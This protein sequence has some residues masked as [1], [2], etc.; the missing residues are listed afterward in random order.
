MNLNE[1][2]RWILNT[3]EEDS[4]WVALDGQVQDNV[5]ALPD[6]SKFKDQNPESQVS[7][8][9]VSKS[10]DENAE[11]IIFEKAV[12]ASKVKVAAKGGG[13]NRGRFNVKAAERSGVKSKAPS[14]REP[15]AAED[16]Q[17]EEDSVELAQEPETSKNVVSFSVPPAEVAA[18]QNEVESLRAEVRL[19][20]SQLQEFRTL[21]DDLKQP[22]LEAHQLLEERERFLEI[23]ENALFDKAQKQEVLATEL[24]QLREE[25]SNR[26]RYV[27]T[28]EKEVQQA[29]G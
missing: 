4:W 9:H 6:V 29:A 24:E 3:G 11:W 22:I 19:M 23:G 13:S 1:L 5:M 28:R 26:E 17:Q 2:Q 18:L 14:R 27:Q 15:V 25:L 12:A 20:K 16:E 10:S 21:A 8:L 7:V